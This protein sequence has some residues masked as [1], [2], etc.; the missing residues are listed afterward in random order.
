[1]SDEKQYMIPGGVGVLEYLQSKGVFISAPCGGHGTC[2]KC[3]IRV[4]AGTLPVG[5]S[6][7][8]LLSE[9]EINAGVR[10]ACRAKPI[11]PV[12]IAVHE[13]PHLKRLSS[14]RMRE[15]AGNASFSLPRETGQA[16]DRGEYETDSVGFIRN[17]KTISQNDT[18][19]YAIAIDIGTTT[20][21]ATLID[22]NTKDKLRTVTSLNRQ[23]IFG[24]D[25]MTRMES[26]LSGKAEDMKRII[27]SDIL[28]LIEGLGVRSHF[29]VN[30]IVLSGNT[31]MYHLL[32][33]YDV[34]GLSR[35]PFTPVS[36]GGEEFKRDDVFVYETEKRNILPPECRIR[37][38]KGYSAF[39]G[40][41]IA[42]GLFASDI[43]NQG[44]NVFFIDI[45]TN[46]EMVLKKDDTLYTASAAAGP[47]LEGGNLKCGTGSVPGAICGVEIMYQT[48]GRP[49]SY[50]N[51]IIIKTIDAA[52]PAGICGT[53]AI[54]AVYEFRKAG[55]INEYGT[56]A[57]EYIEKGFPLAKSVMGGV[58][59]IDQDDIRQIQ[60]AK[61]AICAG[62][63]ALLKRAEVSFEEV[64][65]VIVSGNFGSFLDMQKAGAIG[66]LPEVLAAQAVI[67]GNTSLSGAVKVC[68]S[69]TVPLCQSVSDG[70]CPHLTH[71]D[72]KG[73]SPTDTLSPFT[74]I[75]THDL[76]T[77]D[78][79]KKRYIECMNF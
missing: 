56:F 25:V 55:I 32:M 30:D 29:N 1:M 20:L 42:S 9:E 7:R 28:D 70:D 66:L 5:V 49:N 77:D 71:F 3:K 27:E 62:A 35:Y 4:A 23:S 52:D 75:M 53:G 68:Q 48:G 6:D 11:S 67:A 44:E 15:A 16:T 21:A 8:A 72:T 2:G 51:N 61:A 12:R 39:V 33:E 18:S 19:C 14:L 64:D 43:L 50:V 63:E 58:I 31:V 10:L 34:S 59:S 36:L 13:V 54:E 22:M 57:E 60:M 45:G 24:A 37:L 17:D 78:Y 46:A 74:H 26:A 38:V 65:A 69:G 76:S 79:F 73:L 41:D 47:A 40:G